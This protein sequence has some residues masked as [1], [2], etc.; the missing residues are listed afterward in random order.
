MYRFKK[1]F[2]LIELLV[3][4]V[5]LAL[6]LSIVIPFSLES[7]E[8]ARA[9]N[10]RA[11]V[12]LLVQRYQVLSYFQAKPVTLEFNGRQLA[13]KTPE[14]EQLISLNYIAFSEKS[15]TLLGTEF[16][17]DLAELEAYINHQRWHLRINNE[18]AIW[19]NTD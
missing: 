12:A 15:I 6:S 19:F 10:E 8:S 3:V 2:T 14:R 5:L 11:T 16:K 13:I 7:V 1:G 4:M 18:K 17:T 9:R